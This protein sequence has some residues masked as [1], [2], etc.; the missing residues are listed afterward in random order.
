MRNLFSYSFLFLIIVTIIVS[1]LS[2]PID[3]YEL[4]GINP[5]DIFISSSGYAWPIPNKYYISSYFGYRNLELFGS[6]SYHSGI[7]IPASEGTYFLAAT[8]GTI[9]YLGFSG[10]GGY[11]IILE[12]SE[13][14]VVY[15]HV[16]PNFI[17]N[18]GDHVERSQVIGQVGPFNVYDV[19]NN[20]YKDK[21]GNPTNGSTTG[22]HLHFSIKINNV[23]VNPLDYVEIK[24]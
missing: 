24:S 5:D 9:T 7:D 14:K 2:S 1:I 22:C 13:I 18:V 6:S 10:S 8:S 15:C 17:V 19:L 16:S 11:T 20:P 23:A 3:N 4:Y 21:N 12:N